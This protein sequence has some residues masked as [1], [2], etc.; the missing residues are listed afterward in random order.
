M[1]VHLGEAIPGVGVDLVEGEVVPDAR[2]TANHLLPSVLP[3]GVLDPQD[4]LAHHLQLDRVVVPQEEADEASLL[5][6]PRI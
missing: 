2:K 1:T 4:E 6:I 3:E 5:V